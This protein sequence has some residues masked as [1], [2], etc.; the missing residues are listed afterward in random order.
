[1]CRRST[2]DQ[3]ENTTPGPARA[4]GWRHGPPRRTCRSPAQL[5]L[6]SLSTHTGLALGT[7][8]GLGRVT[9]PTAE[10]RR[11]HIQ[12]LLLLPRPAPQCG[13]VSTLRQHLFPN[14]HKGT[15]W[16]SCGSTLVPAPKCYP[17]STDRTRVGGGGRS[18]KKKSLLKLSWQASGQKG[19]RSQPNRSI[20]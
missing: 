17:C 19:Q 11:A 7:Q 13:A 6:F 12:P 10:G 5:N 20:L 14:S 16:A 15:A 18:V 3:E 4:E 9:I 2:Q 1:M 8:P